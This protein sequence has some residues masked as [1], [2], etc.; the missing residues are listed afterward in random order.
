MVRVPV[1][2]AVKV[3]LWNYEKRRGMVQYRTN[4]MNLV[5]AESEFD[6]KKNDVALVIESHDSFVL[7]VPK[8][9]YT[10]LLYGERLRKIDQKRIPHVIFNVLKERIKETGGILSFEELF[11]I[12]KRT[13]IQDIITKKNLLKAIKRKNAQFDHIK[14]G[15]TLY[16][17]L[18][19]TEC[20]DDESMI[21]EL[22]KTHPYLTTNYIQRE[23]SWSTIRITRILYHLVTEGRCRKEYSYL[24][25]DRF[26]FQNI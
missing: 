13:S 23:T 1:G 5:R 11:S 2:T 7:V 20:P 9:I 17:A 14:E 25:G 21:L 10:D 24:I 6:L 12:F 4:T 18:K 19:S 15:K 22:A 3:D 26:F 16:V 8:D